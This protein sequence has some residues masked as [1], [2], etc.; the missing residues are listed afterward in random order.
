MA[1]HPDRGSSSIHVIGSGKAIERAAAK[2]AKIERLQSLHVGNMS[3]IDA[4]YGGRIADAESSVNTINAKWDTIQAE[5]D[6]QPRYARSIFYWPFMVALMLFEIPVN[7]L[8]FEL[9]F[10]ESP[11]VSLGVAFLVGVILVTLAHRLGL[12]LCRF[13]YHVKKSGW[14]GQLIQ[15]V[16]ISAIIVALI[17]GVSVLRQAYLD[18]ETQP[19]ASFSDMLAGTGAAQM[20]GDM[21][22]AGLGISGWIFF[23]INMGIVAVGLTAAYFSHDPH[24]DFQSADIQLKKAEKQLAQI[25][26]QRADAESIELRRHAN[27]INRASA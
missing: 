18:F 5:V 16:L 25:R 23:A 3:A 24:P 21:F 2:D 26:G 27:Q 17:Y 9:F 15:V 4:K 13:G 22:K 7:R 10:R 12:V 11:T 19:Q 8:S 14:A 1:D 20:A 6:R